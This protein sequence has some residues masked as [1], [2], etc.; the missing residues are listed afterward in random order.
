M[1]GVP[2]IT[3]RSRH[4][5]PEIEYLDDGVNGLF[6]ATDPAG[7]AAQVIELLS[8]GDRLEAMAEAGRKSAESY[9]L[10]NMVDNFVAGICTCLGIDPGS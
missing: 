3:I 9:T 8:D 7:F 4:H 6:A 2:L 1:A 5:G 10:A